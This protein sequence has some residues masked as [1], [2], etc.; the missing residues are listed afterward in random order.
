MN[1]IIEQTLF[2]A[3]IPIYSYSIIY[4]EIIILLFRV[5]WR[6]CIKC[7]YLKIMVL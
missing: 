3:Y 4:I 6:T 2:N 5:T 1:Y 7:T